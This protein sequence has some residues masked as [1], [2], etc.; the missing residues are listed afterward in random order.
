MLNYP[1]IERS[2]KVFM[3]RVGT[4]KLR[5][6]ELIDAA[7]RSIENHGFQGSTIMTISREASMSAG[8]ISHYFGSKQGLILASI[9]HLLEQLKQGLLKRVAEC[10]QE[11]TPELRLH[12]I[13]ETNFSYFQ[14]SISITRT[15]LC[16]WA[17]ALHDPELAR[18]QSVN[19]KRLQRNLLYSYK[20]VISDEKQ[21]LTAAN[22]TA[23]MI[24][25]FWLRSSLSQASSDSSKSNDEFAQAEKLCKQFISMQCQ[26]V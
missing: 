6:Q 8:I 20:Q 1:L 9:R 16:F 11:L 24:D 22:M 2:I 14:Q 26:Q 17:Q 13:V 4:E 21:A 23:A 7:I 15:W 19:S 5:K 12:M 25:G 3:A 10:E 18:L